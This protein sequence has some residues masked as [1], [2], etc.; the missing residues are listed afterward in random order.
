MINDFDSPP[1]LH[2]L[3]SFN[4]TPE[5]LAPI[6]AIH[7]AQTEEQWLP[8]DLPL[9]VESADVKAK[10]T[11]ELIKVKKRKA[12]FDKAKEARDEFLAGGFD[13]CVSDCRGPCL[14]WGGADFRLVP[15]FPT[16]LSSRI[17][18]SVIIACEYEPYSILERLLP[19]IGGSAPIVV[20][21]PFLQVDLLLILPFHLS[22]HFSSHQI[23]HDAHTR[24][25]ACAEL[26]SPSI[27]EP[28][29]RKYQVLPGRCHPEM[30]GMAHGGFLLTCIRVFEN[31]EVQSVLS[32]KRA[33][34]RQKLE[35]N[36][37]KNKEK[38]ERAKKELVVEDAE[39]NLNDAR[40]VEME[41]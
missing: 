21:S 18:N 7:W 28:W 11:R 13:G 38:D 1:D 31:A 3:D 4:F 23:L 37:E 14:P 20:F 26:L 10:N 6:A 40:A 22:H 35:A 19:S 24:M 30:N 8:P 25:R 34:K 17:H 16:F 32:G 33:A 36:K 27:I 29:L 12:T 15:L 41:T 9:D 5:L 39:E 2:I